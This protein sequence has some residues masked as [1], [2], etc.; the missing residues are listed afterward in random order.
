MNKPLVSIITPCFNSASFLETT[1]RSVLKQSYT[2]WELLLIDDCSTDKTLEV[3]LKFKNND[4]RIK[5]FQ[6]EKNVGVANSRNV[7]LRHSNGTFLAFLDSDDVWLA[8]K[9]EKQIHI[10]ISQGA[11]FIFSDYDSIDESGKYIRQY[12]CPTSITKENLLRGSF[13]GCL[14][15]L[16]SKEL[17]ADSVFKKTFHEDYLMWLHLLSKPQAKPFVIREP[18]GQYRQ[19]ERSVSSNKIKSALEQ[20]KIFRYQLEFSLPKSLFYFTSYMLRGIFK[21]YI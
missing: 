7:G 21:H 14:T 5:L 1:I 2:N 17:I 9:L 16:V 6:N 3:I 12:K 15:V 20:W 13:I 11:N 10:A 8:E 4:S 18:L 19:R